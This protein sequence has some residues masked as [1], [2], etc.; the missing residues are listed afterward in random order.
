MA[1]TLPSPGCC[2]EGDVTDTFPAV[3]WTAATAEAVG[4][5]GNDDASKVVA[6]AAVALPWPCTGTV[7]VARIE[8][9]GVEAAFVV[10]TCSPP[11][12]VELAVVVG[13]ETTGPGTAVVGD[14]AVATALIEV[15]A[16]LVQRQVVVA[17]LRE[18]VGFKVVDFAVVSGSIYIMS[19]SVPA[20]LY[21][22]VA[23]AA[24]AAW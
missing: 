9:D 8:G 21:S 23:A 12:A 14:S 15:A 7:D 22:S 18:V 1:C 6:A 19:I 10:D 17:P 13:V 3:V 24:A 5:G 11:C 2:C 20:K 4:P 16:V